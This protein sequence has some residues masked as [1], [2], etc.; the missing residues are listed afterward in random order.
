MDAYK[1]AC[2]VVHTSRILLRETVKTSTKTR[3]PANTARIRTTTWNTSRR[4]GTPCLGWLLKGRWR[5]QALGSACCCGCPV[6][7]RA[8]AA[9]A[10]SV[11]KAA[12]AE[13]SP[14]KCLHTPSAESAECPL[15]AW[16]QCTSVLTDGSFPCRQHRL[17]QGGASTVQHTTRTLLERE[18]TRRSKCTDWRKTW[19]WNHG[20]S[21]LPVSSFIS[22]FSIL[23]LKCVAQS[24]LD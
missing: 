6:T 2:Q 15:R 18:C 21:L 20:V 3:E 14:R 1:T 5:P 10:T 23:I 17:C 12:G 8:P 9:T 24:E 22:S 4:H 13:R 11:T 7:K 19:R 16:F